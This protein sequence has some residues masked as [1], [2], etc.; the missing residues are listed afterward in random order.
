LVRPDVPYRKIAARY[1]RSTRKIVIVESML[2]NK[3]H[4]SPAQA[5]RYDERSCGVVDGGH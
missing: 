5:F 3:S 4:S 2:A 1:R